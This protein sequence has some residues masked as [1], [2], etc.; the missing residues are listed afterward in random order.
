MGYP[1][2]FVQET[3]TYTIKGSDTVASAAQLIK[4]LPNGWKLCSLEYKDG[5]WIGVVRG[6]REAI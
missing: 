1:E 2:A 3:R 4:Q 6:S 5:W